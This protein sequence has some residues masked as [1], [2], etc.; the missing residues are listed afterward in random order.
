M[1][2]EDASGGKGVTEDTASK[3]NCTNWDDLP[4]DYYDLLNISRAADAGEI[5]RGYLQQCAKYH[6]DK[7]V[8]ALREKA[9]NVFYRI[10]LAFQVLSDPVSR[11]K[12]DSEGPRRSAVRK[13]PLL[14]TGDESFNAMELAR[15][16]TA[17]VPIL[18]MLPDIEASYDI[19]LGTLRTGVNPQCGDGAG[20]ELAL[21][22][23]PKNTALQSRL[24]LC[25]THSFLHVCDENCS[26]KDKVCE[27]Y[28]AYLGHKYR[29]EASSSWI[30][31]KS[32]SD[33]P[34]HPNSEYFFNTRAGISVWKE[35]SQQLPP[36]EISTPHK[37]QRVTCQQ[38]G[39]EQLAPGVLICRLSST[40]HLC[41][42]S[43]CRFQW[44]KPK[45][46][47]GK[48]VGEGEGELVCWASGKA[49]VDLDIDEKEE[50]MPVATERNELSSAS[51]AEVEKRLIKYKDKKTGKEVVRLVQVP[52]GIAVGEELD[53][54]N[55]GK[56]P[57]RTIE[58][59]HRETTSAI[60]IK[61][62]EE[63]RRLEK[64]KR[65]RGYDAGGGMNDQDELEGR[66]GSMSPPLSYNPSRKR[67]KVSALRKNLKK[68]VK[69]HKEKMLGDFRHGGEASDGEEEDNVYTTYGTN[70]L[71]HADFD[72]QEEIGDYKTG[73]TLAGGVE[74]IAEE[75]ED[76]ELFALEERQQYM[77][78]AVRQLMNSDRDPIEWFGNPPNHSIG[79][80]HPES[81][82]A[83]GNDG[84]LRVYDG[85]VLVMRTRPP[86][87]KLPKLPTPKGFCQLN[88]EPR[89]SKVKLGKGVNTKNDLLKAAGRMP[90]PPL[91]KMSLKKK[92]KRD[93]SP[94]PS[95]KSGG[96][97][98]D[99]K[100][101][102][103]E[104]P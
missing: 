9:A 92:R 24:I 64:L 40:V 56:V 20:C 67:N 58:D 45:Q 41:T 63:I 44:N 30:I 35:D 33:D 100:K 52:A 89:E 75:D 71:D 88:R 1:S 77:D 91:R 73:Y 21:P 39:F 62:E 80:P 103:L 81:K 14:K 10:S 86:I 43:Q 28:G 59:L 55:Q 3:G 36:K 66:S 6:P 7:H 65:R 101:R 60:A 19:P 69:E 87:F 78:L 2:S 17:M 76:L 11:D 97:A 42:P 15:E 49:I 37:C 25:R 23:L 96:D 53:Q 79:A 93:P 13:V 95:E 51:K 84:A 57:E 83:D 48:D 4:E 32:G 18:N 16:Y 5:R 47:D 54:E 12:Y 22:I 34:V 31:R 8:P 99:L 50:Q 104:L 82:V 70:V 102:C 98:L 74:A 61:R 85:Q 46:R 68:Y 27:L 38:S 29:F 72:R 26:R 90:P 94:M